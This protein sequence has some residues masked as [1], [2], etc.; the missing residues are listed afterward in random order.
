MK[1]IFHGAAREVGRSCIEI[2][3]EGD[4]YLLDCGVKF[5]REGYKYPEGVFKVTELDGLLISHA[6]LDHTGALPFIEHYNLVCP[7]FLT[8][9]TMAITKILLKDSY[10]IAHVKHLHAA[11]NKTDLRQVQQDAHKVHFDKWYKHRKLKFMFLNAGH[12][13]GSAMILCE[14]EGKR[15][16]YTGDYNTR[17][18]RLMAP[19]DMA[20]IAKEH[21]PFD[22]LITEVTY[23]H[24][25]LPD[26]TELEEKFIASLKRVIAQG[27][28]ALVPVF[29][30]GRS[31]EILIMLSEHDFD[32]PIYFDGMAKEVTRKILTNEST[33][34]I[35][36]DKLHHMLFDRAE[37]VASQDRRAQIAQEPGAKIIITTSGMMQGG[38]IMAYL[39][40]LWHEPKNAIFLTG[41]QVQGTNGRHL[42]EKGY[43]H[44]DG[45]KTPV[46]CEVQKFDFSG[47]ADINDIKKS[48]W[49]SQ[50]K[51]VIFQHGDPESVENMLAWAKEET[52]FEVKGPLIGD[53]IE[54]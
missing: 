38:P 43:V 3:T 5:C 4:R 49:Q 41:Y 9:Q 26:R 52:P 10:K 17:T 30:L 19:A 23:G 45:W 22:A 32:C 21:G 53:I 25:T 11:W 44:I 42:M 47:H 46:K 54:L 2:Q 28:T 39:K 18:T 40:H 13:P 31:Q 7:I 48:I 12:I 14:A 36:K 6:H 20:K 51:L 27:G 16:L 50:A 1:L 37:L 8:H 15:V 24:R 33:Y 29:A 35:N 34:V